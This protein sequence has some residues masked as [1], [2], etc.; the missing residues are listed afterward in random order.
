[1]TIVESVELLAQYMR[2]KFEELKYSI[3]YKSA[4]SPR[5]FEASAVKV[6]AFTMP[7]SDIVDGYPN[8]C[9]CVVLTVD[10]RNDDGYTV[11]AHI[12]INSPS[13]SEREVAHP[14]KIPNLY[15]VGT[16]ASDN[17]DTAAD[18]DLLIESLIITEQTYNIIARN[19]GKI[20]SSISMETPSPDLPDFPYAVSSVQFVINPNPEKIGE[21]GF[22]EFY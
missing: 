21:N 19:T 20:L 9:P 15:D 2:E 4:Q 10:G 11:T 12:C 18:V 7:S 14:T 16:G 22:V 1:M 6:Y 3:Q 17:Y 5:E 8:K 13:I